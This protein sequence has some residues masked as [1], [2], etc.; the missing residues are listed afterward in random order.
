MPEFGFVKITRAEE[1]ARHA[2]RRALAKAVRGV[3]KGSGWRSVQ[4]SLFREHGGWFVSV[5]PNVYI[6]ERR[7]V[8][9]V[10]AK[11]MSV[12]PIFWDLV[13]LPENRDQSLSFRLFGAW[14]CQPPPFAEIGIPE[15]DDVCLVADQIL[16]TADEQLDSVS[17]RS[18]E[19]FLKTCRESAPD[20]Y[21]YLACQVCALIALRR[22]P[23][24]LE[25]CEAAKGA[26]SQGGFLAPVGSFPEMAE[27]WIKGSM[28]KSTRH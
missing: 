5:S 27:R 11:P 1:L 13:G 23:E 4:G 17:S 28:G 12:D 2:Y 16:R 8:A 26:G 10:A 3:S 25:L 20:E 9:H 18:V 24:A 7:T 22:E 19:D 6:Y 21:S 15:S 14:T